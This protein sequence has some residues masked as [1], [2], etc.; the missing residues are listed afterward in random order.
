MDLR[1]LFSH[2]NIS[3]IIIIGWMD[4]IEISKFMVIIMRFYYFYYKSY[5]YSILYVNLMICIEPWNSNPEND[6]S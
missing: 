2:F 4:L 3:F 5:Y 1:F 6:I